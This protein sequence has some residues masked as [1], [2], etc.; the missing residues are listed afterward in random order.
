MRWA[1]M[2]R[3]PVNP[4]DDLEAAVDPPDLGRARRALSRGADPHLNRLGGSVF[5]R[6][7]VSGQAELVE[8]LVTAGARVERDEAIEGSTS[9]HSAA[10]N[11]DVKVLRLLL[12]AGGRSVLG[13]FDCLDRTP[14]TCAAD[15]KHLEAATLLVRAGS[16]VNAHNEPRI[17]ET[18]LHHAGRNGD[19]KMA[20]LLLE[21]GADPTIPG[22][23]QLTPAHVATGPHA[24]K[25]R[26]LMGKARQRR[27]RQR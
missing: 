18:A 25:L 27:L 8:V 1:C 10:E 11:G 5:W 23:M 24:D 12:D 4:Q 13:G 20:R 9:V 3:D 6:A 26:R 17:G 2:R 14:L 15:K 19:V 21:A 16:D 7:A 22:W